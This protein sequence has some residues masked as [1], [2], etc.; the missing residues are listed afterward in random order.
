MTVK[1]VFIVFEYIIIIYNILTK[2]LHRDCRPYRPSI[3]LIIYSLNNINLYT[4]LRTQHSDV[5]GK[6]WAYCQVYKR[7]GVLH[8]T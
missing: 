8:C 2:L 3:L 1:N 4:V 6:H 7:S 5:N